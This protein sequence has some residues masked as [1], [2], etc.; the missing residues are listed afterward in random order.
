MH[1]GEI[2]AAMV[3]RPVRPQ[4]AGRFWAWPKSTVS[5]RWCRGQYGC[6][7]LAAAGQVADHRPAAMVPQPVWL[8]TEERDG[9]WWLLDTGLRWCHG[10]YGCGQAPAGIGSPGSLCL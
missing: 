5:L 3:R 1:H 8:R 4:T 10:R 2:V 6:G 7:Q 9:F